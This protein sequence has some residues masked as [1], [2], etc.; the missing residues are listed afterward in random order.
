MQGTQLIK[1]P[2]KFIA[3]LNKMTGREN[4]AFWSNGLSTKSFLNWP[5]HINKAATCRLP[6]FDMIHMDKASNV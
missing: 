2:K 4:P 1:K 6:Q 5:S 3:M